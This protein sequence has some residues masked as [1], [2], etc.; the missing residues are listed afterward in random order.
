MQPPQGVFVQPQGAGPIRGPVNQTG[1][2]GAT[3]TFP[4]VRLRMPS[5]RFPGIAKYR[6]NPQMELAPDIAPFVESPAA[7]PMMAAPPMAMQPVAVPQM[8]MQPVAAPQLA[9]Q[10]V[11]APQ[12]SLQ[13]MM[14]MQAPMMAPQQ[15]MLVPII[16]QQAIQQP[17][18]QV[19][20]QH[21]AP[22][23]PD[24]LAAPPYR[25]PQ[26]DGIAPQYQAPRC[27]VNGA[28][29]VDPLEDKLRRIEAAERRLQIQMAELQ[30]VM[31]QLPAGTTATRPTENRPIPLRPVSP[32]IHPSEVREPVS[33]PQPPPDYGRRVLPP[34]SRYTARPA[35]FYSDPS[36]PVSNQVI[37]EPGRP[38]ALIT[39]LS[40]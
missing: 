38:Q 30:K 6:S 11:A 32:M 10:P 7:A 5:I 20:Q 4:E 12:M 2:E 39:G 37:R 26:C 34:S 28:A 40:K 22:Y 8:A 14:Q 19:P 25:S 21:S 23:S 13:P 17:Q 27:D 1:V 24:P 36:P 35:T 33:P 31:Q 15:M 3:I 9:M 16:P 29:Y 18:Q